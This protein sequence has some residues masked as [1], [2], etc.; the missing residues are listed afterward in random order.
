MITG[1]SGVLG[2]AITDAALTRDDAVLALDFGAIEREDGPDFLDLGGVDLTDPA[3]TQTAMDAAVQRFA[4][5]AVTGA[6]LPVIG[7]VLP[8]PGPNLKARQRK[9]YYVKCTRIW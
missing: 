3:T 8:P 5:S 1:A 7:R 9:N 4:A 2:R 6:L